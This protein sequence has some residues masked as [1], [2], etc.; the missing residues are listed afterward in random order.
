MPRQTDRQ[1]DRQT[2][3]QKDRQ[4]DRQTR[5][6]TLRL[7]LCMQAGRK[8][9]RQADRQAGRQ[10]DRE[11]DRQ[12]ARQTDRGEMRPKKTNR[13]AE[14]FYFVPSF[15]LA[16]C[17]AGLNCKRRWYQA[18]PPWPGYMRP[19][20][21][22]PRAACGTIVCISQLRLH[23]RPVGVFATCARANVTEFKHACFMSL[24]QFS[25]RRLRCSAR[26]EVI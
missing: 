14:W 4:T 8:A 5:R 13:S 7:S 10:T 6:Q 16:T 15:R 26:L 17:T 3:R 11:T 23:P 2:D 9:G 1:L 25:N 24:S 21:P 19:P 22:V 12:T 20:L 18:E